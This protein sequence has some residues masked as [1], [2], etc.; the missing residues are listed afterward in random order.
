MISKDE[1]ADQVLIIAGDCT[2]A[3]VRKR[4][5]SF[6]SQG[7]RVLGATFRRNRYNRDFEPDWQNLDLGIVHDGRYFH[8]LWS[9]MRAIR[10]MTVSRHSYSQVKAIYAV[11][12]DSALL[13]LIVISLSQTKLSCFTY[14]V[15]DIQSPFTEKSLRGMFLRWLERHILDRAD[16]LVV[17][18]PAFIENYFAPLQRMNGSW[19][20]LENKLLPPVPAPAGKT[21]R[22]EPERWRVGYFGA[23]RCMKS[24]LIFQHILEKNSSV[25]FYLRGYPTKIPINTFEAL[26]ERESRL[27]YGGDYT[28]PDD[29]RR[30]FASVDFA[31]GFELVDEDNNSRWLLPNRIYE[32]AYYGVPILAPKDFEVG[33][34]VEKKGIGWTFERP[35]QD[36]LLSFFDSLTIGEYERMCTHIRALDPAD[37]LSDDQ[38]IGLSSSMRVR[39]Q[40]L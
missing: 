25:E 6:E 29:L 32:A 40:P 13:G 27:E 11:N 3:R 9:L 30:M 37:F 26:V 20:L 38:F 23:L 7:W 14:E 28:M 31:W 12:L 18:S 17:T 16:F 10:R 8:R 34:Y 24:W 1:P 21:P 39:L 36:N 33:H 15:A 2:D 35:Y 5:R 19:H 22:P 4:F